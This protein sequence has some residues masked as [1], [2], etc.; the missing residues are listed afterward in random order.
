MWRGTSEALAIRGDK[1][2]ASAIAHC[3][4]S[5][6]LCSGMIYDDRVWKPHVA[7]QGRSGQGLYYAHLITG[8]STVGGVRI[9]EQRLSHNFVWFVAQLVI[10]KQTRL[11]AANNMRNTRSRKSHHS[12]KENG[13]ASLPSVSSASSTKGKEKAVPKASGRNVRAKRDK[14]ELLFCSC[15]GGDDGTPMVQCGN[16]N[17]WSAIIIVSFSPV[18]TTIVGITSGVSISTRTMQMR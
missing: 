1:R 5:S 10:D 11:C 9:D 18:L 4:G 16:C 2:W 14:E 17:E 8:K 7:D 6:G 13:T 15:R 12:G 3:L